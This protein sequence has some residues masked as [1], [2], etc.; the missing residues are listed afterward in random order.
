MNNK[1]LNNQILTKFKL[2]RDNSSEM[3]LKDFHFKSV[4][5]FIIPYKAGIKYTASCLANGDYNVMVLD[6]SVYYPSPLVD[7]IQYEFKINGGSWQTGTLVGGQPQLEVQ[8]PPGSHQ[9][10]VRI[11]ADG[12]VACETFTTLELPNVPS[13]AFSIENPGCTGQA[14]EFTA[15]DASPGLFYE[16]GF[17]DGSTN[18]QQNP[19]K[20]FSSGEVNIT[21]SVTNAFGCTVSH[22]ETIQIQETKLKGELTSSPNEVCEG[23]SITIE[24]EPLFGQTMPESFEW[25]RNTETDIPYAVTDDPLLTVEEGG[26]YYVY[27]TGPNGCM[28]YNTDPISISFMPAPEAPVINGAQAACIGEEFVLQVPEVEGLFYE[29]QKNG[30]AQPQWDGM[31]EI[32]DAASTLDNYTYTVIATFTGNNGTICTSPPGV[33][34]VNMMPSPLAPV[35]NVEV[36]SCEPYRVK[37]TVTNVQTDQTYHWSNGGTGTETIIE[38]DGPL[39]VTAR[40]NTCSTSTQ[41]DLP[42]DLK[43]LAWIFPKGCYSRCVKDN[44]GYV[45]GPYGNFTQWIWGMDGNSYLSGSG[46]VNNLQNLTIDH[47]YGLYL[48]NDYCDLS[49]G[50]LELNSDDCPQ[51]RIKAIPV[52]IRCFSTDGFEGYRITLQFDNL[53]GVPVYAN[54]TTPYNQGYFVNNSLQVQAGTTTHTFFYNPGNGFAGGNI[55]VVL[56]ANWPEG[57][58]QENFNLDLPICRST[59]LTENESNNFGPEQKPSLFLVPNPSKNDRTQAFYNTGK[60]TDIYTIMVRDLLGRVLIRQVVQPGHGKTPLDCTNLA[61]GTYLVCLQN[62]TQILKTTKLIIQ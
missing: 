44:L 33:F 18:L 48:A 24:Y 39:Q 3:D 4:E 61:S 36:L 2:I 15:L 27:V 45:V 26:Q 23:G 38:H 9:L 41:L 53:M 11:S 20:T 10:G 62:K 6:H 57:N 19:V 13:A 55:Q 42:L 22:S 16:W 25:Y 5:N 21:L 59:P 51:C 30:V 12:F 46:T 1:E 14:V 28:N 56:E 58:C 52:E 7:N 34:T 54:L 40:T 29:W 60:T 47:N 49:I 8:L 35:L 37:V 17:S 31:T 32:T 43:S 50:M